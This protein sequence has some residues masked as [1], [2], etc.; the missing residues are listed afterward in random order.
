MTKLK[1]KKSTDEGEEYRSE[2]QE[3]KQEENVMDKIKN[4]YEL[5]EYLKSQKIEHNT[6]KTL[7]EKQYDQLLREIADVEKYRKEIDAVTTEYG[8]LSVNYQGHKESIN[9]YYV[10]KWDALKDVDQNKKIDD[11]IGNVDKEIKKIKD[12]SDEFEDKDP[13]KIESAEENLKKAQKE[14]KVKQKK[15]DE[16]KNHKQEIEAIFKV[17]DDLMKSVD[18]QIAAGNQHNAYFFMKDIHTKLDKLKIDDI[19]VFKENLDNALVDLYY[20]KNALGKAELALSELKADQTTT[21]KLKEDLEKERN[22]RI[23]D[24]IIQ[25]K[26]SKGG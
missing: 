1:E 18:A 20:A 13:R 4:P 15:Y 12:K 24:A 11:A 2:Q 25:F 21:N 16:L 22:N 19:N 23:L 17:L 7:T 3:S 5:I 26:A 14:L 6:K 10:T 8:K 9:S